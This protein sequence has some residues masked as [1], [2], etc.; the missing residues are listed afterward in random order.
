MDAEYYIKHLEMVPHPEEG[1]YFAIRHRSTFQVDTPG[2]RGPPR[3]ACISTIHY[4][5]RQP[6]PM[7]YVHVN[8]QSDISH[9]WHAGEAIAYLLV[10]PA[11][12]ELTRVI[13][14][15][16]LHSGHVLQFTC[17]R[18]WWKAASL[19][20]GEADFGLVSEAVGPSF[21]YADNLLL[22]ECHIAHSKHRDSVRP[23]LRPSD[24]VRPS[25]REPQAD[26]L[27]GK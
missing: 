23:Y 7:M 19:V 25:P 17:P 9:F 14:G 6:A 27:A 18:G 20:S 10:D 8:A 3:R 4:M 5:L 21:D 1:G 26:Y 24:W 22:D 11:T 16:D 2:G 13:L 12:D 15:P